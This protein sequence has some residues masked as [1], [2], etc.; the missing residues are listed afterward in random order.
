M[1][2]TAG[3]VSHLSEFELSE[4]CK[5]LCTKAQKL[6]KNMC[7]RIQ[8]GNVTIMELSQMK[9]NHDNLNKLLVNAMTKKKVTILQKVLQQRL[10][11]QELFTT[12]LNHLRKLCQN[13]SIKVKGMCVHNYMPSC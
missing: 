8:T 4:K 5:V 6:L 7:S 13:I 1:H 11:E 10:R 12:R 9:E 3:T 2:T